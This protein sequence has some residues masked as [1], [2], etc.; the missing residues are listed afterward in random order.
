MKLKWKFT[1]IFTGIFSLIFSITA[2]TSYHRIHRFNQELIQNLSTQL[3]ESKANEA[4]GWLAQRIRELHII[5]KT[6]TV[7]SMEAEALKEYVTELSQDM[8]EYYGNEYGTFGINDFSGLEYITE[9][10][11][12]DVRDR[13]YFKK[14]LVTDKEYL[15]S[16]PIFSKTDGSLITVACYSIYDVEKN[17]VGFV[18]ASISLD[19]LTS[20]TENLSFYEG[21]SFIMDRNGTFYTHGTNTLPSD[22][23]ERV[24]KSI[25]RQDSHQVSVEALDNS[26]TAFLAP[27]PGSQEWYLCT[28]VKNSNLF[29]DTELLISSLSGLWLAMLAIGVGVAFFTSSRI[30]RRISLLSSAMEE[31]QKG[32]LETTLT[33]KGK[34]EISQ[35]SKNYNLM[36]DEIMRLMDEVILTQKEKRQRELQVLQAQINPHF[37]YNTLDTIQW[38]ALSYGADEL[39]DLILALSSF[40]RISLSKG[41]EKITLSKELAHVRSYLEI[42]QYRYRE[43]LDYEIE[44]DEE[45][46]GALI[47]KIII[48]PL[49]ENAIYHGIKPKLVKGTIKIS[50][51]RVK[52]KLM[53]EVK[54]DGVGMD[55]EE[56][57]NLLLDIAS[58]KPTKSYGLY[59]VSQ[60]IILYYGREYGLK[61]ESCKAKGTCVSLSLPFEEEAK[62]AENHH[63]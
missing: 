10:Q 23:V 58:L 48:Q 8:D 43:I 63:L 29:K 54:D 24:K 21:D 42:Q 18:A 16:E 37:I 50:V 4:G 14:M 15:F 3:I 19:K 35:L 40:F 44:A 49:V 26:Y 22:M 31:V 7:V 11:T 38:K 13:D 51:K 41:E 59:N 25:P 52:E 46:L 36:V 45:V 28:V 32:N 60:R 33:I 27:I 17:K 39:S 30:T 12:I 34:D 5:S 1:L 20:L 9:N 55:K 62:N 6:P 56:L 47:P 61:I 2:Y 57:K 53:I